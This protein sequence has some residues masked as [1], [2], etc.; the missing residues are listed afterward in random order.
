M[1]KRLMPYDD[2]SGLTRDWYSVKLFPYLITRI[3]T[4]RK[5]AQPVFYSSMKAGHAC[6]R[7]LFGF[8]I[9]QIDKSLNAERD[10][11]SETYIPV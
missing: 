3:G 10:R 5:T 4:E 1:W 11:R 2:I 8:G 9:S 6:K 7:A